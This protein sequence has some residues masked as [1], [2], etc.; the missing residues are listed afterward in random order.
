MDRSDSKLRHV[1]QITDYDKEHF[2]FYLD[3]FD[4]KKTGKSWM[5][6][7]EIVWPSDRPDA[8]KK[9]LKEH[10]KR[11]KWMTLTGFKLLVRDNPMSKSD[12]LEMLVSKGKMTVEERDFL[13][14]EEGAKFWPS[15]TKH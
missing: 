13:E 8:Y 6:I 5:E 9:Y 11:A 7:S 10:Y 14:S 3:L 15:R 4:M 1:N 12:S 2:Q